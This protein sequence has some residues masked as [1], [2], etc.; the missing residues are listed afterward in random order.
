MWR[1][2]S[3]LDTGAGPNFIRRSDISE[4][5]EQDIRPAAF[6]DICDANNRPLI[7]SCLLRLLVRLGRYLVEVEFIVCERLAT[8]MILGADFCD[9]YVEAIRPRKKQVELDDGT[10]VP[11]VRK[12][13]KR[14]KDQVKLRTTAEYNDKEGRIS[15]QV[16]MAETIRVPPRLHRLVKVVSQRSG[17]VVI[18]PEGSLYDNHGMVCSNGVADIE[19]GV[20]FHVFIANLSPYE[21]RLVKGQNV[22]TVLPH[23]TQFIPTGISAAE[24]LGLVSQKPNPTDTQAQGRE[25]DDLEQARLSENLP[26]GVAEKGD[27]LKVEEVDL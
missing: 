11:I 17:F 26:L 2:V 5:A 7:T 8:T 16:K 24:V 6:P 25:N 20:P 1:K 14:S 18:Q 13:A 23:P 10:I 9:R 27:L 22:A 15:P 19:S 21:K 12:P 4:G 3:I